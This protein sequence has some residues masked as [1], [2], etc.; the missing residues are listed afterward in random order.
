MA[1]TLPY[2]RLSGFYFFWFATLGAI[3]PYWG[4]Y[5]QERGYS[6][7]Q[8]GAVFGSLMGT[9]IIAPYVWGWIADHHGGRMRIVQVATALTLCVFLFIPQMPSFGWMLAMMT[10]YGFFWNA[11]PPQIEVITFNHLGSQEAHYG[12]IRLWGSVGFILS[13]TSLGW[14]VQHYSLAI[15]PLWITGMLIGVVLVS[16][17][18]YEKPVEVLVEQGDGLLRVLRRPEVLTLLVACCLMQL[19][20]GP[21]YSFFSIYLETFGYSRSQ[22]GLLWSLGVFAEIFVFLAMPFLASRLGMRRLFLFA[23]AVTVLR[24]SLLAGFVDN[25]P[26]IML[27]QLMHLA[28]FGIYHAV[29]VN[30]IHRFFR[31]K[32]Q[33]RGQA[34]YSSVSFGLGGGIGSLLSGYLWDVSS[35]TA[36]YMMAAVVAF[37]AWL[38]C[39]WS[40]RI[41]EEKRD[42]DPAAVRSGT[43]DLV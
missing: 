17:L 20:H 34:L 7:T 29:A 28:S 8:I 43:S 33:G 19:S 23:I 36:I 4:L 21:Y 13:V 5:L 16:M 18:L 3:L 42:P 9:K 1:G 22:I 27:I 37:I 11:A 15:V 26:V 41:E 14:I 30:L 31:G 10:L 35:P 32:L 38:V 6:A 39:W 12:R 40:L 24:W 25:Q 2:K